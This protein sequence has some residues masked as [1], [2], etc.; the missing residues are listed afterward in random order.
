MRPRLAAVT[1]IV[2][3]FVTLLAC[4]CTGRGG[5]AAVGWSAARQ[6]PVSAVVTG[7][8]PPVLS[9]LWCGTPGNCIMAGSR[10]KFT[11][12]RAGDGSQVF[13][14]SEA[15]GSWQR[16]QVIAGGQPSGIGLACPAAGSC[17][18]AGEQV[19]VNAGRALVAIQEH[20]VW[21]HDA[22]AAWPECPR[23]PRLG[24]GGSTRC[25]V[26]PQACAWPWGTPGPLAC[27]GR[28]SRSG[29]SP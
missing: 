11:A 22:L 18:A 9:S 5:G 20:G 28:R 17:V 1:A 8:A 4:G 13:T 25:R 2:G 27:T 26:M 29:H 21:G 10:Y 23:G 7:Y 14:V 3:A 15:G 19:T 6:L 16:P 24:H 12:P